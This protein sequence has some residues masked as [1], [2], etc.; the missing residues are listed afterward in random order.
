[1]TGQD[2]IFPDAQIDP[3]RIHDEALDGVPQA[4]WAQGLVQLIEVQEAAFV[5]LGFD[6]VEAFKFARAGVMA[7]AEFF[8]GRQ[9]YLP[10][11]DN[12]LAALRDAEI[13][14]RAHRGN[15]GALAA[16]HGIT[17]R[18]VWRI[19]HQQRR[20]YLDKMQGRL[21]DP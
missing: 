20:L 17:D 19:C 13:Y 7:M 18:H 2:D 21:F 9:V 5:R 15:I 4:S 3:S 1:M 6:K 16:E 14:R 12:L 11:G 8:G 10:R